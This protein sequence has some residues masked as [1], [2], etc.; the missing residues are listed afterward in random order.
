MG[1]RPRQGHQHFRR[2]QGGCQGDNLLHHAGVEGRGQGGPQDPC[3][4][5]E[6]IVDCQH[7]MVRL[8][9]KRSRRI[10]SAPS[11]SAACA[12]RPRATD[13]IDPRRSDSGRCD[14]CGKHAKRLI[15]NFRCPSPSCFCRSPPLQ[16]RPC[17]ENSL[18]MC[19]YQLIFAVH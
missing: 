13:R 12:C 6:E 5:Q 14:W 1:D 7:E 2:P 4:A 3:G 17:C 8:R 15:P 11:Y 18:F 19:F 16:P 10:F 9:E